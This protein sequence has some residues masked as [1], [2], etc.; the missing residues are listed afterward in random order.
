MFEGV[1]VWGEHSHTDPISFE[2]T[3]L[4]RIRVSSRVDREGVAATRSRSVGSSGSGPVKIFSTVSI[5]WTTL[6]LARMSAVMT[7]KSL[8]N[9]SILHRD[10]IGTTLKR[11]GSETIRQLTRSNDNRKDVVE[12]DRRQNGLSSNTAKERDE[13]DGKLGKGAVGGSDQS[14]LSRSSADTLEFSKT[15]RPGAARTPSSS[16]RLIRT[17]RVLKSLS[18]TTRS[19]MLLLT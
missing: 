1:V 3:K 8:N 6:L 4:T 5:L 12:K 14:E 18:A 10:S 2:K 11:A 9:A 16:A 13:L 15:Y 7:L 17:R 19:L